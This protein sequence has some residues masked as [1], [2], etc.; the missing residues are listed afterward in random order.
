MTEPNNTTKDLKF[1]SQKSIGI[2]TFIGGPLAAGYLIK[3]NYKALNENDKG[4]TALIISIIATVVIFGSLFLIPEAIMDK[5]PNM[6][7]PAVYT[8]LVY[9]L[10][11]KIHGT[12]LDTHEAHNN[13][14]YSGWKAAGI[15]L[16]SLIVLMAIIFASIFLIPDKVYDSYDSEIEQFTINE[17]ESLMF[18]EHFSTENDLTLLNE[19]NDIAIPKWKENIAIIHRTNAIEGLPSELIVQNKKLLKYSELRLEAFELFKKL[20]TYDSENYNEELD[21][22]HT[23][24][25]AVIESLN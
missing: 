17:E 16:I 19:I 18:Y 25:D 7:I 11:D 22:I 4:K 15:G 5:V 10:V 14:F 8:G 21:R 6:V 24:I 2:A 9:L 1:Y 23:E 3:E 20:I 13:V 12:I